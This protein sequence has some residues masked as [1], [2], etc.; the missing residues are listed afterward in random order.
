[1]IGRLLL[2]TMLGL[3]V[4]TQAWAFDEGIE[5]TELARPQATETGDK[6]E[7]LELFW[8]GCPHCFHL[9]PTLDQWLEKQGD[10]VVFRRMPAIL[11]SHWEP[12]ARAFY[13]A[14]LMEAQDKI[15]VPLFDAM[16]VKKRKIMD[17]DA[18][19]AFAVEQ[20]VDGEEFRKAYNSFFVNMKV[21]RAVELG[22]RFG[23]D[24]VPSVI[25]NGKYRTSPTQTGG[26]NKMLPVLDYLIEVES[27]EVV[28]GEEAPPAAAGSGS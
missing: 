22:R 28:A 17:E 26:S 25:V 11:G 13:A 12:H 15:H 3:L 6:I 1:M 14:E 16:H 5:Y 19:V 27:G 20:G 7:V 21:R 10:N 24:G 2:Q 18:L 8:Y 23:V 9:E 4:A